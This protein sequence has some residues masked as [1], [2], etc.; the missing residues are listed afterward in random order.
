MNETLP[1]LNLVSLEIMITVRPLKN[2]FLDSFYTL[3]PSPL[4]QLAV[5]HLHI[6]QVGSLVGHLGWSP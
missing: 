1:N 6:H 3:Q 5:A 2:G 4:I